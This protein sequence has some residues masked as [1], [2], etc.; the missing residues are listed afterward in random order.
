[1][2][3]RMEAEVELE[4][5][6]DDIRS[7]VTGC[8]PW[9]WAEAAQAGDMEAYGKLYER[10]KDVVFRFLLFRLGDRPQAED[11]SA[12]TFLRA[13]RRIS[14]VRNQGKDIS[15]WFVTIARNLVLDYY[16][17]SMYRLEV[18][19]A[20]ILDAS[21]VDS[22]PEARLIESF[23]ATEIRACLDL[24]PPAQRECIRLRYYKDMSVRDTALVMGCKEDAVKQ[25]SFRAMHTLRRIV[26]KRL[27]MVA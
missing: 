6:P 26:P 13:L 18:S 19:T 3:V 23:T 10:Y 2:T 21:R 11:L 14:T 8:D 20:E 9:A 4:T 5:M 1:M 27:G 24:L 15:A 7:E 22:S 17:S 16:K 12:E 25:L